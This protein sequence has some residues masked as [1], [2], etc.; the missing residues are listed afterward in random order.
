MNGPSDPMQVRK[1]GSPE[2]RPEM[3]RAQNFTLWHWLTVSCIQTGINKFTKKIRKPNAVDNNEAADFLSRIPSDVEIVSNDNCSFPLKLLDV[4]NL[5]DTNKTTRFAEL[6]R[7]LDWLSKSSFKV[8]LLPQTQAPFWNNWLSA[9]YCGVAVEIRR[10]LFY[11]LTTQFLWF[12]ERDEVIKDRPFVATEKEWPIRRLTRHWTLA[13]REDW[14]LVPRNPRDIRVFEIMSS[15]F[16]KLKE[17]HL[18]SQPRCGAIYRK[19]TS[20]KLCENT[21]KNLGNLYKKLYIGNGISN[22][23]KTL[24]II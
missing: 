17:K 5:C 1:G 3:P 11:H 22:I 14:T 19:A 10:A 4:R 2:Y 13:E 23:N 8:P 9:L 24:R 15:Q 18:E 6:S 21:K 7:F 20:P 16:S 12:A